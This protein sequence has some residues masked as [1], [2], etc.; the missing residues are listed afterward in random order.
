MLPWEKPGKLCHSQEAPVSA[1]QTSV[2]FLLFQ[3]GE[4]GFPETISPLGKIRDETPFQDFPEN[5]RVGHDADE[6]C[7]TLPD[8]VSAH[9]I[10]S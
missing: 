3:M 1:A 6:G 2:V 9:G 7:N 4:G 10:H 8:V 5:R